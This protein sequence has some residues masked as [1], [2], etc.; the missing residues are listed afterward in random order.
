MDKHAVFGS[1][2]EV[3]GDEVD[4]SASSEEFEPED[5]F[6]DIIQQMF[7]MKRDDMYIITTTLIDRSIHGSSPHQQPNEQEHKYL[8]TQ[9]NTWR[10]S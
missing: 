10:R 9:I 1:Y 3:F 4:A 7:N 2:E 8:T 6:A 5:P